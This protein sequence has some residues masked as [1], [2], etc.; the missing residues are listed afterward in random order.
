MPTMIQAN[1]GSNIFAVLKVLK[2]DVHMALT[3]CFETG[4][5]FLI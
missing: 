3:V 4:D 2:D 5:I 1:P